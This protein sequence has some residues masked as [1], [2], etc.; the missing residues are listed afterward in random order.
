M[1]AKYEAEV[2]QKEQEIRDLKNKN[3]DLEA[4]LFKFNKIQYIEGSIWVIEKMIKNT[5]IVCSK[6][7]TIETD[8]LKAIDELSLQ[9][10]SN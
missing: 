10:L 4:K 1:A 8:I 3:F 5:E 7:K 9:E 6:Y 2:K